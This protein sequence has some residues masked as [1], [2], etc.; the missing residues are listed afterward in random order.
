MKKIGLVTGVA[1]LL[2]TV[3]FVGG[4]RLGFPSWLPVPTPAPTPV[5][6]PVAT[7]EPPP[8]VPM[9][10]P[11]LPTGDLLPSFG[12][13]GDLIRLDARLTSSAVL[14]GGP[15]EVLLVAALK[16]AEAR[17]D[18]KGRPAVNLTLVIDRSG[19]MEAEGKMAQVKE[20]AKALVRR[21]GADDRLAIVAYSTE[22][23]VLLP[24]S[25]PTNQDR[26]FHIIDA[27]APVGATNMSEGLDLGRAEVVKNLSEKGV[28]RILLLS[29]GK[30]NMGIRD[31]GQLSQLARSYAASGVTIT[32]LGVGTDFNEDLMVELARSGQGNFHFIQEAS[33]MVGVF[34]RETTGLI[35]AVARDVDLVVE[36]RPGVTVDRVYGYTESR[37]GDLVSIPVGTMASGEERKVVLR[38]RF[39]AAA[40]GP[41]PMA[42]VTL[43]YRNLVTGA[44]ASDRLALGLTVTGDSSV[45]EASG[46]RQAL[47]R[48]EAVV[49]AENLKEAVDRVRRNSDGEARKIL[50]AQIDATKARNETF[51]DESLGRQVRQM[52]AIL[53]T[54]E[55]GSLDDARRNI[56]VKQ[57]V[58]QSY[59]M[60]R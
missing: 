17:V 4:F 48:A 34:A 15:G 37:E 38:F 1:A 51:R 25:A 19:S 33:Q 45:A 12:S 26:I 53:S 56:V 35:T 54:I 52:E 36:P 50:R 13:V 44:S 21:L 10:P 29:D 39:S 30:A 7:P 60:M 28:N 31:A 2:L 20:A 24:S 40:E 46:D 41:R 18:T 11:V 55:G 6:T 32:T 5:A 16:A 49:A 58:A 8:V 42:D 57:G 27:M 59:D 47:T 9:T 14:M 3:V 23:E 43:R 22:A